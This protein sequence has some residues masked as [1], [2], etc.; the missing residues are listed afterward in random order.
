MQEVENAAEDGEQQ[1]TQDDD[2]DDHPTA[3]SCTHTQNVSSMS[4]KSPESGL[5]LKKTTTMLFKQLFP[6]LLI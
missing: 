1:Q 2:H 6:K 3:L 4:L 5:T